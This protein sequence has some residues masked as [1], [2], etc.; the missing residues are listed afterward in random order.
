MQLTEVN[1]PLL[2]LLFISR[3]QVA[4]TSRSMEEGRP[5]REEL[6]SRKSYL[7]FPVASMTSALSIISDQYQSILSLFGLCGDLICALA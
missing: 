4:L 2:K 5:F 3:Y 1:D 7:K 6:W